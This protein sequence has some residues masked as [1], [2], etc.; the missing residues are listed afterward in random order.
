MKDRSNVD[1]SLVAIE[2]ELEKNP[3]SWEAW[4]A[5]ADV[6]YSI[7][8]YETAVW[9]CNKS[10]ALNPDDALAWITE[11]N[12]LEQLGRHDE[13]VAAIGKAMDLG[14]KRLDINKHPG[15]Y[16]LGIVALASGFLLQGV[17]F[18]LDL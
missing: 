1:I 9:C 14:Y 11:G 10:L 12:A 16:R 13:A 4:A 15:G 6:L 5:K 17:A 18:L 8:M 2:K 7:E 3:D